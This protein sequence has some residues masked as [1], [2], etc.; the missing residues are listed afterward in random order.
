[1]GDNS[2]PE[3]D[4]DECF[5]RLFLKGDIRKCGSISCIGNSYLIR[6]EEFVSP[7]GKEYCSKGCYEH[8][9]RQLEE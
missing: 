1:M 5:K 7:N 3:R 8:R 4:Y 2:D 9:M 6:G